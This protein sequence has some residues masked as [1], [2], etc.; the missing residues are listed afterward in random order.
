MTLR[1]S[2]VLIG[3]LSLA[4]AC[5][6]IDR[7]PSAV[8]VEDSESDETPVKQLARGPSSDGLQIEVGAEPPAEDADEVDEDNGE[9]EVAPA[10]KKKAPKKKSPPAMPDEPA[11]AHESE[12]P[13]APKRAVKAVEVDDVLAPRPTPKV[14]KK[15]PKAPAKLELEPA[16]ADHDI[17]PADARDAEAPAK[18]EAPKPEE[19]VVAEA[20]AAPALAPAQAERL[21]AFAKGP[22][23]FTSIG[24]VKA[25]MIKM[26]RNLEYTLEPV[27]SGDKPA[28]AVTMIDHANGDKVVTGELDVTKNGALRAHDLPLTNACNIGSIDP[29]V[30]KQL[31]ASSDPV[32]S[33]GQME[34]N[35]NIQSIEATHTREGDVAPDGSMKVRSTT[36]SADGKVHLTTITELA[37]DGLPTLAET[38]GTIAKGPINLN[39]NLKLTREVGSTVTGE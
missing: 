37:A 31:L 18:P 11:L 7:T 14:A 6:A 20:P 8:E 3:S 35:G 5:L 30:R 27:Q 4:G 2:L 10:P 34:V 36:E 9:P 16:L 19:P 15:A 33:K 32:T 23:K 13:V 28:V 1:Y 21:K 22:L 29:T 39:V 25:F 26:D 17:A 38:T 12:E 24:K